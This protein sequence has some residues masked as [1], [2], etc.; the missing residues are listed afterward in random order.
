MIDYYEILKIPH[1]STNSEIKQAY[2]SL[3]K[4]HHP[5]VGGN[6]NAMKKINEAYNILSD[7]KTKINY[8]LTWANVDLLLKK[9]YEKDYKDWM[10][11]SYKEYKKKELF[12]NTEKTW[13]ILA[14]VII[15]ACFIINVIRLISL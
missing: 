6:L 3:A 5:D 10:M 1:F 14:G 7:A 13:M 15:T 9:K 12:T 8:D 2:H 11:N 4:Q